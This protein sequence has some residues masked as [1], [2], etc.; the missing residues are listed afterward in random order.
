MVEEP[1]AIFAPVV[2]EG[3]WQW[4]Q[5]I[6]AKVA[7]PFSLDGVAGAGEGGASIRIKLAKASMS[8]RTAV[9]ELPEVAGVGEKLSVS[10]GVALKIQSG[11]SSRSCGKSWF[12]TPISTLYASL[13]N[14]RSDLFCAFH[15][16]RVMVP[17]FALRFTFPL[18]CAFAC[19]EIPIADFS[20]ALECML[21]R[22]AESGIASMSPA[23]NTGVGIRKMMFGFPPWP[24]SGIPAGRKSNW[25]ML[26]PGASV[27]PVITKMSCT[28]PSLTPLLF[29]NRASRTGPFC[30]TNH[31]T[32]FLAPFKVATAIKGFCAR[33]VPP[34]S[35]CEWQDRHWLELKRGPSPLLAP[36]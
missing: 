14:R 24:V 28:E 27:R 13:A 2:S 7:R 10:S 8:E 22:M 17:S 29:L 6:V 18:R 21:A 23:P 12:V 16:K 3:V 34:A 15:P 26:Q 35:G 5:P 36:L 4:T 30:V 9:F 20:D 31:G 32:V 1:L 11:V 25:A 33:L 19:P